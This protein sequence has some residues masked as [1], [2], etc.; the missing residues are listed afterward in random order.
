MKAPTPPGACRLLAQSGREGQR[1]PR[2]LSGVK[3]TSHFDHAA[4]AND[5]QQTLDCTPHPYPKTGSK[6]TSDALNFQ[7]G[8][9]FVLKT[10]NLL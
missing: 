7:F 2:Q 8:W 3:R 10:N 9:V 5:P 4:A 6:N 1:Q